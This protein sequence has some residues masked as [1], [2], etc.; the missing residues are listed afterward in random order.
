[1]KNK[2]TVPFYQYIISLLCVA[3]LAGGSSYIYFDHRVKKMSQEGAITNADLSKVQDLYNEISTNYVGEVDKNELVEGALKGMS[4]AIGDPYS[5]YLN[6]SAANEPV[7]AEAP[8]ADSPAE[9]AGIKEGDIIEKVDGT[10]TKGMK[11]AE[12]VSKVRGKKGTSVELTIQREGET[13]NISIKRGKIPV[14]TVTG[15]LDKNDA[16]IGSIKITSFGKKTYQELKETITNLRGKGAKSFVIDVRQN[17]GG[18]LDQAERMASM[19]LK[20][21]ETIVQFEDKKGRTMKEVASKEL[22]GGFKVKEPVA[23]IIDG[24]SASASEI[25]AAA[26][27]ESAN[28]PLIGTKTFG[29]GTVQTVK[30]LNDQTEIKL[31]VL[32]WLTPKGEWINEKGIEPTIKA[33]YP[34]YAYLKLIPRDKT[35]KEGDQSEDIQN[36]NA[37]LAVLAYP[38]DENNAN[39]T[40]ETKAA[41]SDLQQKNG[42]PVTGEIDNETATK[43]EATL[44]KLILENDAAYDTAVKEIQKN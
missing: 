13:K 28:V 6:E 32:K 3:F 39:Y 36:L 23:V 16:Q 19:F 8:V 42:L 30:D 5:T 40:A 25:F 44:G 35:L 34:E 14:K 27:H 38:I 10:A 1:M 37:I 12:V 33:D 29:K 41:V 7:V 21:G 4:E 11:L 43:I 2:R 17:P 22:D 20:N 9:K 26:L 15:E 18:L 24:N 31:T